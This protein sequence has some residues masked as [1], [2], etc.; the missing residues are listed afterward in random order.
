MALYATP[1]APEGTCVH[2]KVSFEYLYES[3][4]RRDEDYDLSRAVPETMQLHQVRNTPEPLVIEVRKTACI[5]PPC[6]AGTGHCLNSE[7]VDRWRRV[8]LHPKKGEN[9]EKYGKRT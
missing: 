1:A 8:H 5:C 3:D 2:S 7:F 4:M 9:I 6:V